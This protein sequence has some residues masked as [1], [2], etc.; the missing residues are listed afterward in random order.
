MVQRPQR[1][2]R[3]HQGQEAAVLFDRVIFEQGLLDVTIRPSGSSTWWSPPERLTPELLHDTRRPVA[4]GEDVVIAMGEQEAPGV[5]AK[6]MRAVVADKLSARYLAEFH[7]GVLDELAALQPDWVSTVITGGS[8]RPRSHPVGEAIGSLNFADLGARELMPDR[9]SFLRSFVYQSFNHDLVV[10]ADLEAT[11][12]VTRLFEPM[13]ARRGLDAQH[14]GNE[15]LSVVVPNLGGLPWEAIIASREHPGS[16]EARSMLREFEQ[17]AAH[18]GP[19]DAYAFLRRV[20]QQVTGAYAAALAAEAKSLP[21][22]MAKQA[23]LTGVAFIA[24][25]GPVVETTAAL[26]KTLRE[27]MHERGSW[28][29]A[30]WQLRSAG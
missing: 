2:D 16:H 24:A 19:D 27:V 18:E 3:G 26:A 22:E 9:D 21:D 5:P 23:L 25:V 8:D 29:A 17:L 11:F 6:R 28:S 13:L 14:A 20:S 10:A 1:A 12:S 15:A 7:C 30:L 4:L